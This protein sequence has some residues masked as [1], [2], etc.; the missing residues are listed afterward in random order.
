MEEVC[1]GPSGPFEDAT[2]GCS[3]RRP[4]SANAASAP[5]AGRPRSRPNR[6]ARYLRLQLDFTEFET[7]TGGTWRIAG[8]RDYWS[9]YELG[10]HTSPTANMHDAVAAVELAIAGAERLADARLIDLAGRDD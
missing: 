8:C 2:R 6:P 5:L 1:G 10:W 7:T 4:T 3:W 9:K